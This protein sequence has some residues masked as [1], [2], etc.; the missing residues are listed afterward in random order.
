MEVVGSPYD[1]RGLSRNLKRDETIGPV[2]LANGNRNTIHRNGDSPDVI[3]NTAKALAID[4]RIVTHTELGTSPILRSKHKIIRIGGIHN[5]S[6]GWVF[7]VDPLVDRGTASTDH[8]DVVLIQ[9][10]LTYSNEYRNPK[11][12]H[13]LSDVALS[14]RPGV[15]AR[16]NVANEGANRH[17]EAPQWDKRNRDFSSHLGLATLLPIK[18]SHSI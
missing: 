7:V 12:S 5:P 16:R 10:F 15:N 11:T 8:L 1:V 3:G 18:Q 4:D 2:D 6:K 9:G 13:K 14:Q 17:F